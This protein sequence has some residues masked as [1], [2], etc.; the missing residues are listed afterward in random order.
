[1]KKLLII[2]LLAIQAVAQGRVPAELCGRWTY[3]SGGG[4]YTGGSYSV[5]R[6]V[7]LNANGTYEYQG[8]SSN[9]G[10]NG[11]SYGNGYDQGQW[12]IQ[13]ETLCAKSSVTGE[14]TQYPLE[15]RNNKNGDPMIII[16]GD[17][18]VTATQRTPWPW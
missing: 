4:T 11:Q 14:S 9:S 3:Y 10:G 2:L 18:Y 7:V 16:D 6:W 5:S 12:W 8:E 1:M 13:G 17:A 15:L